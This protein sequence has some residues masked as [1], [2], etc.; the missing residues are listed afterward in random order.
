MKQ[1]LFDIIAERLKN[2]FL[3]NFV[4][5]W[6]LVNHSIFLYILI[7]EDKSDIKLE[8]LNGLKFNVLSDFVYPLFLVFLYVYVL[9]LINLGLMR[10]KLKF[11]A[12]LLSKYKND[13][14]DLYYTEKISIEDKRLDLVFREKKK[15]LN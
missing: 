12:P 14:Q 1:A 4:M 11:V 6:I 2:A 9:P 3:A 5:S 15:I 7:S 13:E 8:F 10:L